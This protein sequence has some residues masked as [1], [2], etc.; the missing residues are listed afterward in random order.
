MLKFVFVLWFAIFALPTHASA[1]DYIQAYVPSAKPVGEGR[2]TVFFWDVYDATLYAPEG[3]LETD[4]PFAL[5]LAYLREIPGKKIADRSIEEIRDQGMADEVKLATWHEQMRNIFP[6]VE[7][8]VTLTGV[9]DD[10]T[11]HFY[12]NGKKI[13]SIKDDE[14]TTAFFDIWLSKNTSAPSLRKKLLGAL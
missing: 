4:E 3:D 6:D 2:L 11:A 13:G 5:R 1:A 8:G 7:E 12:F 14:F 10:G 9:S